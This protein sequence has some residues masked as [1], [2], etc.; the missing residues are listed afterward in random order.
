MCLVSILFKQPL[1]IYFRI[2]AVDF[3]RVKT[4]TNK[5][6]GSLHRSI[7]HTKIWVVAHFH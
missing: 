4:Q 3:G 7:F 2:N 5:K 6:K 1:I